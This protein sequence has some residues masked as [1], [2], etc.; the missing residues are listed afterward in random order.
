MRAIPYSLSAFILSLFIFSC[1]KK[2]D[3][4]DILKITPESIVSYAGKDW[5][6][7]S[8]GLSSKKGYL[9][10]KLNNGTIIA[11]IN[12]PAK[13]DGAPAKNFNLLFNINRANR[14]SAVSLQ[15]ADS[16]NVSTG[17]QLFLDY[18]EKGFSLMPNV[19]YTFAIDNYDHQVDIGAENLVTELKGLNC[20]QAALTY[21]NN[22]MEMG[23]GFYR[24][25]FSVHIYTQ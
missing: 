12:L 24:G 18:Y 7:I 1:T 17:D 3:K 6:S 8:S 11:T 20:A 2:V 13:D 14:V 23:A 4:E 22:I 10:T 19:A 16:L 15:S 21:N 25:T 5:A 9:Y